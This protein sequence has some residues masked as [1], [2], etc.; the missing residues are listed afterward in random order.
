MKAFKDSLTKRLSNKVVGSYLNN[1][2]TILDMASNDSTL[3]NIQRQKTILKNDL[4]AAKNEVLVNHVKLSD[5]EFNSILAVKGTGFKVGAEGNYYTDQEGNYLYETGS[6]GY[7]VDLDNSWIGRKKIPDSYDTHNIHKYSSNGSL[8]QNTYTSRFGT[9]NN[10]FN[11]GDMIAEVKT[12][13]GTE[14]DTSLPSFYE[15]ANFYLKDL[16]NKDGALIFADGA[17][18]DLREMWKVEDLTNALKQID[19]YIEDVVS[20]N[21]GLVYEIEAGLKGSMP[22]TNRTQYD[23]DWG[24]L[25]FKL[26]AGLTQS[27]TD[28]DMYGRSTKVQDPLWGLLPLETGVGPIPGP[29]SFVKTGSTA[30]GHFDEKTE[31]GRKVGADIDKGITDY[32]TEKKKQI[33][34]MK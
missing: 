18:L 15:F 5:P 24:N 30:G 31:H 25:D 10:F 33:N 34:I 20:M 16:T 29:M 4:E 12:H 13:L 3:L 2:S 27:Y 1:R 28:Y 19:A 21:D 6:G 22:G 23:R 17:T 9:S 7:L 14:G 11:I 32:F 8:K 26:S